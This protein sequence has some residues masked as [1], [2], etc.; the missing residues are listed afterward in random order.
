MAG[1]DT[2]TRLGALLVDDQIDIRLLMRLV[3][4]E[5]NDGLFVSCEATGGQDALD[6]L[7]R[8]DPTV[9][10][11]DQMMPGMTGIET[12]VAIRAR[13]PNQAMI[14]CSA[15][16]DDKLLE[17]AAEVGIDICLN[18][19]DVDQLPQALMAAAGWATG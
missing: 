10:V 5:A 14:L 19:H 17:H 7:D 13:R 16:L 9:V 8:C 2:R 11:L 3:I 6:Q 4:E 18:K 15:Y 1:A 12:A